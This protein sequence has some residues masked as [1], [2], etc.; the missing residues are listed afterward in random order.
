MKKLNNKKLHLLLEEQKTFYIINKQRQRAK[1]KGVSKG[2]LPLIINEKRT[3]YQ[4]YMMLSSIIYQS[5]KTL[6]YEK[7]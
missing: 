1:F 6:H 2:Y 5:K 4:R 7:Q 3:A